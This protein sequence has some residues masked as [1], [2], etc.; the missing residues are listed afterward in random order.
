MGGRWFFTPDINRCVFLFAHLSR[1]V[2]RQDTEGNRSALCSSQSCLCGLGSL[3]RL[4]Q[5]PLKFFWFEPFVSK[6]LCQSGWETASHLICRWLITH[7]DAHLKKYNYWDAL[8]SLISVSL[9]FA[10][11][12]IVIFLLLICKFYLIWIN[13]CLIYA[14]HF[15]I[16]NSALLSNFT[17]SHFCKS[18]SIDQCYVLVAFGLSNDCHP[19]VMEVVNSRVFSFTCLFW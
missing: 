12:S 4:I 19:E 1:G 16:V 5:C 18:Y 15:L 13:F 11:F 17:Y 9:I 7:E 3:C 8:V 10:P 2:H 6:N 14:E